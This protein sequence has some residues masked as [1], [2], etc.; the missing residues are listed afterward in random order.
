M[1]NMEKSRHVLEQYLLVK[2]FYDAAKNSYLYQ[3]FMPKDGNEFLRHEVFG[4]LYLKEMGKDVYEFN[5]LSFAKPYEDK[6]E[7][8]EI[9]DVYKRQMGMRAGFSD[10]DACYADAGS[11]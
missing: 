10:R 5:K 11:V 8:Q 9:T 3:V 2:T 4:R 1:E 7:Y 6:S